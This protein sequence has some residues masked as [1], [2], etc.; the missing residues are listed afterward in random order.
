MRS[1]KRTTSVA[2]KSHLVL[3]AILLALTLS[4]CSQQSS[5]DQVSVSN[6]SMSAPLPYA[7]KALALDEINLVVEVIVDG[8]SPQACSNLSVDQVNGTYSCNITLS[9]GTHTL[10]LV[11]SVIDATYGTVQVATTSSVTVDV[12]PGQTTPT[13]FGT[14]TYTYND[15][16]GDGISNLDELDT[17]T[18]PDNQ[19]PLANA[20]TPRQDVSRGVNVYLDGSAS[21]D[22]DGDTLTFTWNQTAG[23]DV[24]GDTGSLTGEAPSFQAPAEV[25]TLIFELVVNDGKEDSVADTVIVNVFEDVDVAYFVDG[26]NGSDETGNGGQQTP[27]ASIAKAL[28]EVTQEQQDIYVMT[29]ASSGVYDETIDPCPGDPARNADLILTIPTG[30]SLYGGYDANWMRD[31]ANNPS[32]VSTLHHGFLFTSVDLNAWFSGFNV[33]SG[34]SPDPGSSVYALSALGGSAH[35]YLYDN[36]LTA[37]NV[38]VGDA[39]SPGTSY[40]LRVALIEAAT[41]ERNVISAGSGGDGLDVGDT[42]TTDATDG[43]TGNSPTNH[44]GTNGGLDGNGSGNHR[45]G[46]GGNAGE[47]DICVFCDGASGEQGYAQ[48]SSPSGGAG[49]AGGTGKVIGSIGN[50]GNSGSIG[51]DGDRGTDGANGPGGNSSGGMDVYENG[52]FF[53][54]FLPGDGVIGN[55]GVVGYGG[56]GGGGGE[57]SFFSDNGGGGAGG[58]GGGAGGD[59]GPGGP[60]GGASIGLFI[61]SVNSTLIN[62]NEISGAVGGNGA[63]GGVGQTGGA[64]GGG[65]IGVLGVGNCGFSCGG[66]GGDGGVG[67]N[68]G[69]G[70]HGG[71]GGGGPSYGIAIGSGIAP[72][73]SNNVINSGDG[74]QGG[75]GGVG[76]NGG[77]GGHSYAVYD[78]DTGDGIVPVLSN[79]TSTFGLPGDGGSTADAGESGVRNWQ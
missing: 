59:G 38:G 69:N 13:D 50:N 73:V 78:S 10:T 3:M 68:G 46:N 56:G 70:G 62:D 77:N 17:G 35:I 71:A 18:N 72:T 16:D 30:T 28:C 34:D 6:D 41:I 25:D 42:F 19:S 58:G 11:Y 57:S 29:R 14:A 27:F 31:A 75:D 48:G 52:G 76:G 2:I 12:V 65:G 20:G 40:G 47:G 26:D 66:K 60:G 49:G 1:N 45:G 79:N 63:T 32:P 37:G 61:A 7:L 9:G 22:A 39:A 44:V 21:S 4:A 67:G 43:I 64:G 51:T 23:L 36:Q 33:Q 53:A 55:S 54:T 24:T 8:G 15:N 74:G 5:H